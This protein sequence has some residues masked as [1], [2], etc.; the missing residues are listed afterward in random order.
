MSLASPLPLKLNER[1]DDNTIESAKGILILL[2]IFGH[3]SNF[4]SPE[5][6]ATFSIKFY[7]VACFL[8]LPFIYD[9]RAFSLA[10]AKDKIARYYVPFVIFLIGYSVLN[11]IVMRGIEDLMPWLQDLGLALVMGNAP[12]LDEASGLRALWF[13]PALLAMVIAISLLIGKLKIP[14]WMLLS[15]GAVIHA[16]IGLI[17]EPIKYNI[18]FGF[19]NIAYLFWLGV[20]IRT[21]CT[22][23][24]K[25]KLQKFSLGFF[26]VAFG[27]ILAAFHYG[28]LI[29]FPVMALPNYADILS[30]FI[31]DFIIVGVFMFLITTPFFSTFK[32]LRWCGQNS[33]TLYLTHL[34]FLAASM[35]LALGYFDTGKVT[36]LSGSV[37]S[38][39]FLIALFGSIICAIII[40]KY[41]ILKDTI[42]PRTWDE[43]T[44]IRGLKK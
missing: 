16:S 20:I 3:A 35:Q 21:L 9:I 5:P 25:Q 43:W 22:K 28:T 4:W 15:L 17:E 32:Y 23:V 34:L 7:H 39:I 38:A 1:F 37:V 2:V 26:G 40:N 11:L 18:P 13:L 24:E 33:L 27:G 41:S 44:I 19:V 31:H 8:L 29:K 36:F 12:I 6:F 10:N 30:L 14:T 42:M